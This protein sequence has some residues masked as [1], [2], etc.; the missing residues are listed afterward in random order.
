MT[1]KNLREY[2]DG[3]LGNSLDT[4]SYDLFIGY[5]TQAELFRHR[6]IEILD[7]AQRR[8]FWPHE[9]DKIRKELGL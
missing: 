9:A 1:A 6:L 3:E 2:L 8:A 7:M 4:K 5:L